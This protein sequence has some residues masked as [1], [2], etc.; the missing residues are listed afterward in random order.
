[1]LRGM[2]V[3]L[4]QLLPFLVGSILVTIEHGH[5]NSRSDDVATTAYWYQAGR[6]VPLPDLPPVADR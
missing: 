5:A 2:P 6:T 4:E 3:P 1:M